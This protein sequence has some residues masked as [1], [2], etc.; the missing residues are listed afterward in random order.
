MVLCALASL[1]SLSY[2]YRVEQRNLAVAI[3][4]EAESIAELGALAGLNPIAEN[5][6]QLKAQGLGGVVISED[7]IGSLI[8]S[9]L[10]E[11][12][13]SSRVVSLLVLDERIKP[14]L[15]RA[16]EMRF[17]AENVGQSA[18]GKAIGI[19]F[20]SPAQVRATAIG[21]PQD[22][23][24]A[25]KRAELFI[26]ARCSNPPGASAKTV[27]ET[28]RWA[29]ELGAG[30]FLPLGDQ[31]LGRRENMKLAS[32]TLRSLGL[33][34]A[35]PEFAKLGGD[36][37]MLEL[38]PGNVVRLHAA[39]TAELDK[40]PLSEAI[41]RYARA[42]RERN[43]RLLLLRPISGSYDLPLA[44]FGDFI[45]GVRLE[46]EKN[47]GKMGVPHPFEDS[48]VPSWLF[49]LIGLLAAPTTV[50]L[51]QVT[52]T[53]PWRFG[54]QALAVLAGLACFK[55]AG[56][57]PTALL[58]A[59]AFP[60]AGYV[61]LERRNGKSWLL[62]YLLISLICLVGGLVVAGLHNGLPFFV[63][64]DQFSGVKL[65]HFAP[66]GLIGIY[67]FYRMTKGKDALAA[68]MTWSQALM[69]L[70]VLIVL[71]LMAT[72]TGN[73]NPAAVSGFELK[74]RALLDN[75]LFVRPRT[76]EFLVGHPLL[77]VGIGALIAHRAGRAKL[78][79]GW[80][81]LLLTAGAIGQTSIV[82]TMCH[83]HTP[84]SLSL[85]RLAV[86]LVAGGIVGAGLWFGAKRFLTVS[87]ERG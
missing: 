24:D 3:V 8:G 53:G 46:V 54:L 47:G 14:T 36:Q 70:G 35:S 25:A 33:P 31:V 28:L 63:R 59:M 49:L 58:A 77:I 7:T 67:F 52:L 43:M 79:P 75:I 16:L 64:A 19:A 32:E 83:F 2:R 57:G 1:Y 22:L 6:R 30:Y 21:L 81:A 18:D 41:D 69:A 82:N 23:C 10:V 78:A 86:G 26:V 51:A 85:A 39:Q 80:I 38:D 29:K 60:V 55:E 17:P 4:A 84:L 61:L 66:I 20:A 48:N 5:L 76:K 74:F 68:P 56:R 62:E 45:K 11:L 13:E 50:W 44:A 15:M 34:Y 73:D 40:L 9:G 12:T 37:N 42:A 87:P 72:R 71:A 65:A 27:T